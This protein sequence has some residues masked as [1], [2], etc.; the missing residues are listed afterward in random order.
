MPSGENQERTLEQ[1]SAI[2]PHGRDEGPHAPWA[3]DDDFVNRRIQREL[4]Q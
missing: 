3:G 1:D 2:M 4:A